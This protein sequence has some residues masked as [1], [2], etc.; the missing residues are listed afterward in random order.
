MYND[1]YNRCSTQKISIDKGFDN[2]ETAQNL[3]SPGYD[4]KNSSKRVA[5]D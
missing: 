2:C 4:S 3:Y 5:L 1:K